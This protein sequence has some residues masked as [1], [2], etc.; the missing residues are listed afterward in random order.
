MSQCV[1]LVHIDNV[2]WRVCVN[3]VCEAIYEHNHGIGGAAVEKLLKEHSLVPAAVGVFF[4]L[5]I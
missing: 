4:L 5:C 1:S 2:K 3:A